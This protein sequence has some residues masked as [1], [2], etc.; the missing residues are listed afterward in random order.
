MIVNGIRL[1]RTDRDVMDII[2]AMDGPVSVGFILAS[3]D[4]DEERVGR[5]LHR[6]E[7]NGV[8]IRSYERAPE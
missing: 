2:D 6:L 5:A 4:W 3:T 7:K 8:L 1:G